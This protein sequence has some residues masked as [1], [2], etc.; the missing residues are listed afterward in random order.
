[1]P[2]WSSEIKEIS[3]LYL[4]VKGQLPDLEKELERLV[5]ADDENMILIYS[6]RC[7]EVIITDLCE[8]ELKRP[9]KTEPLK[10]VIDK[11]NKE[12]KV[13]S[14]IITS[15]QNLNS[16][17]TYGAHP[18]EFDPRQ[19]RTVLIELLTIYEWYLKYRN[20][21]PEDS[22]KDEDTDI[23]RKKDNAITE[24]VQ[25]GITGTAEGGILS[26]I[27]SK[28]HR[29]RTGT[30]VKIAIPFAIIIA[31]VVIVMNWDSIR[32]GS[33]NDN[34]KR[35]IAQHHVENAIIY[36]QNNNLDSAEVELELALKSDSTYSYA[37]SS[38]AA[39][40]YRQG[41]MNEAIL[42][43]IKAI[44]CD[45]ANSQAAYNLAIN[46]EDKKFW[47][48]ALEWYSKA[49]EID[50]AFTAAYS[51]LGN[52]YNKMNKPVD[53]ILALNKAISK[54]TES[55]YLFLIYKN[56]GNAYL[57]LDQ[58]DE[59]IKHLEYSKYLNPDFPE[60]N[61]ILARAYESTGM[62]DKIIKQWQDYIDIESDTSKRSEASI[63]LQ[64]LKSSAIPQ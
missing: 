49:I 24:E 3:D 5:K 29:F 46:L 62:T 32:Q 47:D 40:N 54:A 48:Q 27:R 60:T 16:L 10:G 19:V 23:I 45:P 9:R 26:G 44:E 37:W 50:S 17:S 11:L 57:L 64:K 56:L 36:I 43:T 39:V 12:E 22:I 31:G 18:K 59:A 7:L 4:S 52:L 6:R 51:A 14:F 15:M 61:L 63:H 13:P 41:K 38:L 34:Y 28:P 20:I 2:I 58:H 35:E 33:G 8:R 25:Q 42:Q 1:M 21:K 53:A 55:E 30:L